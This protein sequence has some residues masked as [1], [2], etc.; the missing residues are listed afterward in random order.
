[1]TVQHVARVA[2]RNPDM[3]AAASHYGLT[4]VTCAPADAP[5][6]GGSEATVRV[7]KAALLPTEANLLGAYP[8]WAALEAACVSF[9]SEVNA[10]PHRV[11]RRAPGEMLSAEQ[12]RL[13]RLPANPYTAAFGV[14]RTVGCPQPM[15]QL[16]WCLYSVPWTLAGEVVW[17]RSHGTDVVITHVGAD[18]PAEVARHRRTTP[19]NPS[20]EASHFPA[21]PEGAL[22][23]TPVAANEAEAEFL[24]IGAG[25]SLWLSEAG[26]AGVS[27]VR[28]KMADAVQLARL[29]GL[30]AVDRALGEAALAGR[31]AEG[32]LAAIV[33][34]QAT[35]SPAPPRRAGEGHTLQS[36]TSAWEGFGR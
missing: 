28:A 3:V 30:E 10:R 23:R 21:A 9:C 34:H 31:F 12:P 6:K 18:G 8:D 14:T 11:T 2:I 19:G 35:A 22:N 4:V 26:A 1:V 13:H 17:V 29:R 36:G 7:A 5:S 15:V 16:D 33:A 25:A 27:R 24:A 32:D 20:I